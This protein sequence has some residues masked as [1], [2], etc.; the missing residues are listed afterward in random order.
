MTAMSTA[1]TTY[2]GFWIRMLASVI[3]SACVMAMSLPLQL[4]A[5]GKAWVRRAC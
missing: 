2:A 1:E 3:D 5:Y 4:L